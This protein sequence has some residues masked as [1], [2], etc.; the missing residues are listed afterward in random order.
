MHAMVHHR[1][2]RASEVL[3][4]EEVDTPQ[5]SEGQVLVRVE[6]SSANPYDWHFIRGEPWFMRLG[7]GGLRSPKHPIPGGDLAGTVEAVGSGDVGGLAVGDEVYGFSHGAFAEYLAV[8]HD[9]LARK[10]AGLTW[11][12]AASLP[13]AAATALQGLKEIGGIEAGQKVLIIGASGGIGSLAVQMARTWGAEVTGVCSTANVGLV[14]DLGADR[15]IDY[16]TE[17]YLRGD[18]RYDLAFQLGGTTSPLAIRKVL[19]KR[20]TLVLCAG[21]GD[22]LLGPMVN[23]VIGALANRLVSQTIALISTREDTATLDAVREMIE[24]GQIHPVID[25]AVDFQDAGFAVDEIENGSPR[26]KI[27]ISGYGREAPLG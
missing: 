24:A 7:P 16:R 20:G 10:P 4:L 8:P 26:G 21:D 12:E 19:A 23:V 5:P 14:R 13:L 3:R 17:D 22:R 2:G 11:E 9:R 1:F 6:A 15:V 25:H 27:V 18:D